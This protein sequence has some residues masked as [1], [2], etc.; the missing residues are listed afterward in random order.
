ML[1]IPVKWGHFPVPSANAPEGREG[2][3]TFDQ[4]RLGSTR[5]LGLTARE[6]AGD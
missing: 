4:Y 3:R 5:A 2:W 1:E 6:Y